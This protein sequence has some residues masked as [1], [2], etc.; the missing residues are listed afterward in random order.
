MVGFCVVGALGVLVVSGCANENVVKKD[1]AIAPS[2]TTQT[3]QADVKATKSALAVTKAPVKPAPE[4]VEKT[5]AKAEPQ[6]LTSAL[7]NIYFDFD[8]YAL[9]DEARKTL[10]SNADYLRKSTAA[11]LRIE[12]NCDE[13]GSAEYNIALG[14]KRAKTALKYLVTMGIPEERLATISYGKEKP[15]DPSHEETAWAKN[16]RDEFVIL[17]K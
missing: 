13:R 15:A 2:A 6:Q 14:E 1:E 12:G 7:E 11:N 16:R 17:S 9:S 4:S 8:S 3:K 5:V 10:T